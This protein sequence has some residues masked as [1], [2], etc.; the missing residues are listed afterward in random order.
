MLD[1][2][3]DIRGEG[4][5]QLEDARI[6]IGKFEPDLVRV[7]REINQDFIEYQRGLGIHIADPKPGAIITREPIELSGSYRMH[8]RAGDRLVVF[9]RWSTF[10]FPQ[11]P[12]SFDR[13]SSSWRCTAYLGPKDKPDQEFIVARISDDLAVTQRFYGHVHEVTG[14]WIGIDI[15]TRPPGFEV[16]ASV[17][18][19]KG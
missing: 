15:P 1:P 18:V 8:P 2:N 10:Y 12:I 16:L 19:K 13:T 17:A 9:N 6:E 14:K 5:W 4:E 3:R 11:A 7:I